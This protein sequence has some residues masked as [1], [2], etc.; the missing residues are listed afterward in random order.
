MGGNKMEKRDKNT[1]RALEYVL[2]G[3]L[4]KEKYNEIK[5]IVI[6]NGYGIFKTISIFITVIFFIMSLVSPLIE[7]LKNTF[8]L[9]LIS[10]VAFAI[11][12][13]IYV[14]WISPKSK[15]ANPFIYLI[16][17]FGWISVLLLSGVI[18]TERIS[19]T[20]LIVMMFSSIL[21]SDKPS[22]YIIM[23]FS[24]ECVFILLV[25]L[26]KSGITLIR[27]IT[28]ST[29]LFFMSI[30]MNIF[31]TSLKYKHMSGFM[32]LNKEITK[33]REQNEKER[34]I[35]DG[36][37]DVYRSLSQDFVNIIHV[38]LSKNKVEHFLN[39]Q[40]SKLSDEELS[41]IPYDDQLDLYVKQIVIKEDRE[42]FRQA[43]D[44]E[45][46]INYLKKNDVLL[47]R[48]GITKN[49]TLTHYETKVVKESERDGDIIVVIAAH[50]V[51]KEVQKEQYYKKT[52]MEVR[53]LANSDALTGAKNKSA[54]IQ[55]ERSLMKDIY[56]GN[57]EDFAIIMFD[58][59]GLKKTNDTYGHDV[60]DILIINAYKF[61]KN[62][63][64]NVDI[65]RIGGDEF[66][67]ILK[68]DD[69]IN[70]TKLIEKFKTD[71]KQNKNG[72]SIAIGM[73]EYDNEKDRTID[74][75]FKR[76]D[77]AMYEDKHKNNSDL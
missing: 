63:F 8:L 24:V 18:E 44:R 5:P 15:L 51:E 36:Q 4:T 77:E 66:V 21:F 13:V 7:D 58:I 25:C 26:N 32:T 40:L 55:V 48:H 19:V 71:I 10:F 64:N 37:I 3:G 2:Y 54:Y 45:A 68:E 50:D 11:L 34:I 38:N 49:G 28:Y 20:F 69:F 53:V 17:I 41:T 62:I 46:L 43:M 22:N 76:A 30:A 59:N 23:L 29:S 65:Y 1:N 74:Q 75:V 12:T 61:I 6:N 72:V 16:S 67:C 73:A 35:K 52:I 33:E 27:D 42:M 70:R 14:L 39:N 56:T 57:I 9:Y 47:L 31:Q 60:G